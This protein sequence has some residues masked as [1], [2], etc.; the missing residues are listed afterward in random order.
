MAL[1]PDG[2][3]RSYAAGMPATARAAGAAGTADVAGAAGAAGTAGAWAADLGRDGYAVLPALLSPAEVHAVRPVVERLLAGPLDAGCARPNNTLV[4]LRWDDSPVA[5]VVA[6]ERRVR[7]LAAAVGARDLRW[8]SG[9]VSVKQP[10]SLPLW[11]HQ[12]W[13]CWQHPVSYRSGAAQVALLCYLIGTDEHT[14]AL[15]VLPGS[16]AAGTPL[17]AVLP[18]AHRDPV[19]GD[20]PRHPAMSDQPGQVTLRLRAGDAVVMDYRLLHGTHANR[21]VHRRDALLLNFA[22]C[23]RELPPEI[24]AHLI[25]HPALPADG[26]LMP[27]T[28]WAADLL[29]R[30]DGLRRDLEL[31]R[32]APAEF[33]IG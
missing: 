24:R 10:R 18:A 2:T 29:P 17:H 15:R 16:H 20:D 5:A 11:W 27:A 28:G 14:G 4:P 33:T 1:R 9:Y 30:F 25:R 8:I 7:R 6:D 31:D 23:W 19:T 22:P 32:D 12:D 21:G 13:W 26:E 3:S